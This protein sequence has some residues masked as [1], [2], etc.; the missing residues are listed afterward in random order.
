LSSGIAFDLKL[1]YSKASSLE[2]W[3]VVDKI[4]ITT[5]ARN[6]IDPT[7]SKDAEIEADFVPR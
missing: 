6:A 3:I 2:G 5:P 4:A 1:V 7:L